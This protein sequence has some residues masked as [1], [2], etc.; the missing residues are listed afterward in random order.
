MAATLSEWAERRPADVAVIS[1]RGLWTFAEL[2]AD[3]NRLAR[4]LRRRGLRAGDAL[5]LI[6]ENRPEF[7]EV[8]CACQRSGLRLTRSTGT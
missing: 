8:V 7:V 6:C 5:A 2:E 1:G 3:A 4:A